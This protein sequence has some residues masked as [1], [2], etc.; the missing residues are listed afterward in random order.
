MSKMELV[1]SIVCPFAQR[2]RIALH[3]KGLEYEPLEIEFVGDSF[4]K[5]DWFL[6]LTPTAMMPVLK[7]AGNVVYDSDVVNEYIEEVFP[8]PA[9]MPSDP[10]RRALVRNWI[11]YSNG[12]FLQGFYGVIMSLETERQEFYKAE[13]ADRLRYMEREGLAK[14]SSDGPYW[15][16]EQLSLADLSFYP[17]FERFCVLQHYRGFAIP[18]DCARLKAWLEAMRQRPGVSATRES[19]EFHIDVYK[20][21]AVGKQIGLTAKEWQKVIA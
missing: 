16:G 20:N 4:N 8:E 6:K 11:A 7:H 21:Y 10:A 12:K 15:L 14:L 17:F 1:T 2:T 13:F 19:D 5:P 3:E 18:D 9:L